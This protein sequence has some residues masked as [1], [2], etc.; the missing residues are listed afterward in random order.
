MMKV[1][2]KKNKSKKLKSLDIGGRNTN[3]D[4]VL[5]GAIQLVAQSLLH[6]TEK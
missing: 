3:N 6:D 4:D 5:T 1:K 2:S